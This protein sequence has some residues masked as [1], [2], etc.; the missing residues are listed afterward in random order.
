MDQ[1]I[2][3]MMMALVFAILAILIRHR[4][5]VLSFLRLDK[6]LEDSSEEENEER[7]V[8]LKRKIEDHQRELDQLENKSEMKDYY[9]ELG[10]KL[11]NGGE[12]F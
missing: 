1:F 11:K 7:K 8:A 10:N 12:A 3:F 6:G 5:A 4:H 9:V 2:S